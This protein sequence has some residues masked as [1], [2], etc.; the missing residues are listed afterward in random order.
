MKPTGLDPAQEALRSIATHLVTH[1]T[2]TQELDARLDALQPKYVEAFVRLINENRIVSCTY[3]LLSQLDSHFAREL[4]KLLEKQ[5]IEIEKLRSDRDEL[6]V[7]LCA[8]F[9]ESEIDYVVFKTINKSGAVGVDIDV[10]IDYDEFERSTRLLQAHGFRAIDDLSKKYATGFMFG[11]N[12]TIID[13]HTEL[14]V[15]G[16]RYLSSFPLLSSKKKISY[17]PAGGG[18]PFELYL[19]NEVT[20]AIVRM[21]HSI[22]KEANMTVDDIIEPLD[23]IAHERDLLTRYTNREGLQTAITAF[24]EI[25]SFVVGGIY[26]SYLSVLDI[27]AMDLVARTTVAQ[28]AGSP[29]LPVKLPRMLSIDALF[30]R[31]KRKDEITEYLPLLIGSL[32]FK[33]NIEQL[34]RKVLGFNG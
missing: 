21:S 27:E 23:A 18:E 6:L 13:L 5:I 22:I 34:G 31:L 15:L 20:D 16:V 10:M 19:P 12:P 3:Q 26:S 29:K 2:A 9:R 14:A 17:L 11:N 24:V 33:R 1:S 25:S 30:D 32:R 8:I 7:K 28:S 4:M